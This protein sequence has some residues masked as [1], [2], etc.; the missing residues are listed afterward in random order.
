VLILAKVPSFSTMT[1]KI[2]PGSLC[3]MI[4]SMASTGMMESAPTNLP[5][6]PAGLYTYSFRVREFNLSRRYKTPM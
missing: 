1:A 3:Y 4:D 6:Y 5:D 2:C